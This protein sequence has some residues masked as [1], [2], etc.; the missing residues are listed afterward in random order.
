M[1]FHRWFTWP[2]E[3]RYAP[4]SLSV[5]LT[6]ALIVALMAF[7]AYWRILI[8]PAVIFGALALVGVRDLL[9]TRHSILRNYPIIGHL[10]FMME[11]IRPE[12]R[13]Y[14]FEDEK[15]GRP[16]SRDKRAIVYQRAKDVL[17]S[18]PFGTVYDVYEP[19]FEWLTH[20][21]APLE[22]AKELF[23][24]DIGGG[25]CAK[26]YSSSVFN[27][28]GMS[29]GAIS[30]NA[31]RALNKGAAKGDFAMV[32]GEGAVSRYHR[33]YGGDLIWQVASGYFGC[34]DESGAFN[35][36]RFS[37]TAALDQIKMIELKLSQGAKPGHGGV[38]PRAKISREIART[39]HIPRDRDC[40][41]PPRHSAFSTPLELMAFIARLRDLSG[42]KPVGF[43]LCVGHRWE[44]LAICK[45]MV[46][47]GERPD[48]IVVD[49]KEG[50]TG[51]A[52]LEFADHI[53]MPL[54]DGLSFVHNALIGVDLRDEIRLGASGK[55]ASAFDMVRVMAL[56]ADFCHAGRAFMFA[57]G[58]VQAQSCHTD[59]CPTGVATQ[60][61]QRQRALVVSDKAERVFRFHRS[62]LQALAEVVAAAGLTHPSE[63]TPSH[64]VQRISA[65]TTRRFEEL[66]PTLEPGALLRGSNDPRFAADWALARADS[67]APLTRPAPMSAPASVSAASS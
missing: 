67:F 21:M 16:F 58:C 19:S 26:P 60:N 41:S 7:P 46:E 48:F 45:A 30:P 44:F 59:H 13:Q 49:G 36:E 17:D 39:R 52:P 25:R 34:R 55:I 22:P 20:S 50:G 1:Q 9:Q 38:L 11:G 42:G 8:A 62:T 61:P 28:S 65:N 54:R 43:K 47:S 63:L 40:I 4:F 56:G 29:F 27:V 53:G 23:R 18:R 5:A 57:L 15:D 33:V 6:I 66:Y 12:M 14:F 24:V 2:T 32:T 10:R 3:G 31:I 51:A 35:P 37:E 64:L